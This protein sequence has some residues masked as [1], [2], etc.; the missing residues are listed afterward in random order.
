MEITLYKNH[1]GISV[2]N[3]NMTPVRTIP[4]IVKGDISVQQPVVEVQHIPDD[5]NYAYIKEF[6]RYY[7]KK[8]LEYLT[9]GR[10]NIHLKSDPL[11]SFKNDIKNFECI[12]N[13]QQVRGNKYFNDGSLPV[14]AT[15]STQS[16]NFSNGFDNTPSY[17][18]IVAGGVGGN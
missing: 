18:L 16:I 4:C 7:Y 14:L 13:K 8:D 6:K 1:S 11:E 9:G 15:D 2:L 10:C 17:V 3:K 12:I 5:F